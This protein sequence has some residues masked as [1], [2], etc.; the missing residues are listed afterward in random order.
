MISLELNRERVSKSHELKRRAGLSSLTV[1]LSV[2]G[3]SN[4]LTLRR[5]L[6]LRRNHSE[7]VERALKALLGS[8]AQDD[9]DM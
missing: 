8:L 3:R 9:D 4:L 2:K 1:W 7:I 5:K 6:Y